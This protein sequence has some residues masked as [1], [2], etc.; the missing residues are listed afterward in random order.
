[1]EISNIEIIEHKVDKVFKY[2]ETSNEP[3]KPDSKSNPN[4]KESDSF[5]IEIPPELL[6]IKYKD[7]TLKCKINN[8]NCSEVNAI[9]RV[10][11]GELTCK[12]L[13]LD[14]FV[15]N[16]GSLLRDVVNNRLNCLPIDQDVPD[17][18]KFNLSFENNSN[19]RAAYVYTKELKAADSK[20]YFNNMILFTLDPTFKVEL[21]ASIKSA[22]LFGPCSP[23]Y[24]A[25]MI[26][27]KPDERD[28]NGMVIK[29]LSST[30]MQTEF[31]LEISTNG[32]YSPKKILT[33]AFDFIINTLNS[34]RVNINKITSN[35][36]VYHISFDGFTSTILQLMCNYVAMSDDNKYILTFTSKNTDSAME[37]MTREQNVDV[38]KK[39][40][41]DVVDK[42]IARFSSARK[43]IK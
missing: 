20:E 32:T 6:N 38:I 25:N 33:D 18:M 17:D 12:Y 27:V 43:Q 35:N 1:M 8:T 19:T 39:Y 15:T 21:T 11:K 28:E 22:S 10:C 36:S 23:A 40:L 7:T 4:K 31:I 14:R 41:N 9:R 5:T 24:T 34:A 13:I 29:P 16:D 42:I 3:I 37:V 30:N 26:R 2:K